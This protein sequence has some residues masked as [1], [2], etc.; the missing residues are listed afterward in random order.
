MKRMISVFLLTCILTMSFVSCNNSP[1][2]SLAESTPPQKIEKTDV[3]KVQEKISAIKDAESAFEAANAYYLLSK[4]KRETV[5][6]KDDLPYR[7]K[8]YVSDTRVRD[9]YMQWEAE[10]QFVKFHNYL[11]NKLLNINSYTVN[12][13]I[14]KVFFDANTNNYYLY[15]KV[16][17][18]AQ[19]KAGGY[20]RYENNANYFVWENN[21]WRE[22]LFSF[23]EDGEADI[24]KEIY[25]WQY[26]EYKNLG[27]SFSAE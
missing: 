18:S 26:S 22:L 3:E 8:N 2:S 10:E 21:Y 4:E 25:T 12:N 7:L 16:D 1:S 19:N 15:I 6:N 5:R 24:I 14:S 9:Y 11:R 27:F 23:E 20:T 13:E 17:Y